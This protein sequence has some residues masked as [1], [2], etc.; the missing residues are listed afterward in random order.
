VIKLNDIDN[1]YSN[2]VTGQRPPNGLSFLCKI[3]IE[4]VK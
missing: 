2:I 3:L 1:R 4:Y